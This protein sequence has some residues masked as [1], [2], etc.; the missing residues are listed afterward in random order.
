MI[1]RYGKGC[2]TLDPQHSMFE[3]GLDHLNAAL[4]EIDG[5]GCDATHPMKSSLEG[6]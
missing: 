6:V 1:S 2:H 4:L 5:V 3:W